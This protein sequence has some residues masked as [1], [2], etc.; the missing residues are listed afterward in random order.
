M[1]VDTHIR[2]VCGRAGLV[3][4]GTAADRVQAALAPLVPRTAEGCA[5]MHLDLI[6]LGRDIC[7]ARGPECPGCPLLGACRY[8]RRRRVSKKRRVS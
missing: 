5:R 3:P 7:H 6:W 2:R 1:P 8:A 4:E